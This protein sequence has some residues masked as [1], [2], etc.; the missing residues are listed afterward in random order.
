MKKT[1]I[2]NR[3]FQSNFIWNLIGTTCNAVTSL[4]YMIFVTRL[5]GLETAGVFSF[6]FSNACVLVV[7]AMYTGRTYQISEKGYSDR[8][9]VSSRIFT[10][11]LMGIVSIVMQQIY[12]NTIE[13]S[14]MLLVWCCIKM[15]EALADVWHGVIQKHER[16][17]LVGKSLTLKAFISIGI[18][19]FL[20]MIKEDIV[21]ASFGVL[22]SNVI[23]LYVYDYRN[24]CKYREKNKKGNNLEVIYILK[25]GAFVFG[26]NL[27][28]TYLVNASKYAINSI[29][30][31]QE[32]AIY[33][34]IIMPATVMVL[35]GQYL[36]QPY[37]V[38]MSELFS[39]KN[40]KD[41]K[42][43]IYRISGVLIAVGIIGICV[44]ETIGIPILGLLYN[45]YL[46]SYKK[47]LI[48][49]ILGATCYAIFTVYMNAL[50]IMHKN[51]TQFVVLI[52]I[53]GC[54]MGVAD[55]F[56]Q[57]SDVTGA[58][59]LYFV[60]ML[61]SLIAVNITTNRVLKKECSE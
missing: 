5:N 14:I 25:E 19:V 24:Y 1:V 18:F 30:S 3:Q 55:K 59:A 49:V 11:L 36:I 48:M 7:I 10:C 45:T 31:N 28:S 38:K 8:S 58:V 52:V 44:A 9:F 57:W 23:I 17:D 43:I 21:L 60:S 2:Q 61:I 13:K 22:V 35:A 56:V 40:Q 51:R 54:V 41:F 6:A 42:M 12:G 34:I 29:G 46:A 33:G 53:G 26:I 32:Q 27:I 37:L 47:E 20:D 16:L 50:V 15:L 4:F 39:Q